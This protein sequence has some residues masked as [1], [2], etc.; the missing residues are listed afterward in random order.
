MMVLVL[1]LAREAQSRKHSQVL[2][3]EMRI[4]NT[5]EEIEENIG[6][7]KGIGARTTFCSTD[8]SN[9]VSCFAKI[10]TRVY[11]RL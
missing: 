7:H 4:C 10:Y 5:C 1:A 8:I 3:Q 6:I 2:E 9:Y 11:K